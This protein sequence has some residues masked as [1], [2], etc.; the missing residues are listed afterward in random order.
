MLAWAEMVLPFPDIP[1]TCYP[2][3]ITVFEMGNPF[4]SLLRSETGMAPRCF[5]DWK[6]PV[7]FWGSG[8][9]FSPCLLCGKGHEDFPFV[10]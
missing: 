7:G 1:Q 9:F 4:Y 5:G 3:E 8:A 10:T 2:Q 6:S